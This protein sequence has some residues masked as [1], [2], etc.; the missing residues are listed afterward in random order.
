M[1]TKNSVMVLAD[2]IARTLVAEQTKARLS[3]GMDAAIIAAHRALGMG[4]GRA[5][6]FRQEYVAAMEELATMFVD[7]AGKKP[8]E[9]DS[10]L[11]YSK[12]T[13]DEIIRRI[14][15]DQ[16][17]VPVDLSYGAAYMDELKRIRI[18]KGGGDSADE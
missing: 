5:E 10:K 8:G 3:L 11:V 16:C 9:G 4:P 1:S 12:A 2:R 13:R 15:G 6:R 7:D 18:M 17:V 14:L